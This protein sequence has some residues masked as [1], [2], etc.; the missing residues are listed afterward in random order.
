MT[1]VI[2]AGLTGVVLAVIV[3]ASMYFGYRQAS[4]RCAARISLYEKSAREASEAARLR[5]QELL[6]EVES[7]KDQ[8]MRQVEV[9]RRAAR[10]ARTELKR[11]R[12][13]IAARERAAGE[14]AAAAGR[15][16]DAATERALLGSCA[17][18]LV[19]VAR[20]ADRIA[21]RLG[22]LQNYVRTITQGEEAWN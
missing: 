13:A 19:D 10:G 8:Y 7:V 22:G 9:D 20:E 3:G 21:T 17:A 18:E 5:E 4:D 1:R 14:A 15:T 12:D 6:D 11:L 2:A 16:D